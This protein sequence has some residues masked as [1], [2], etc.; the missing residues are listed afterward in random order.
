MLPLTLVQ[1]L[2]IVLWHS[3]SMCFLN[4]LSLLGGLTVTRNEHEA[5]EN[6]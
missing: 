1:F 2:N 3:Y 6:L 5:L 4:L